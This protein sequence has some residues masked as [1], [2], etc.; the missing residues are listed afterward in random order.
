MSRV[1]ATIIVCVRG[2]ET[3]K[4]W[5]TYRKD[6]MRWSLRISPSQFYDSP[7]LKCETF[8]SVRCLIYRFVGPQVHMH[9]PPSSDLKKNCS[10]MWMWGKIP[11]NKFGRNARQSLPMLLVILLNDGNRDWFMSDSIIWLG[12]DPGEMTTLLLCC[13]C[14][15]RQLPRQD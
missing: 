6:A 9:K 2:W 7:D 11:C 12:P 8:W 1:I 5:M 10:L 15:L 3:H 4:D 14:N 13:T